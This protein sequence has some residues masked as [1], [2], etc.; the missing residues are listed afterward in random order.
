MDTATLVVAAVLG[1]SAPAVADMQAER[2]GALPDDALT[3]GYANPKVTADN[4]QKTVCKAGWALKAQPQGKYLS[5]ITLLQIRNYGVAEKDAAKYVMDFRIP[6]SVGG[7]PTDPANLWPQRKDVAWNAVV[8][9]KLETYVQ[10]ELCAG[11]MSLKDA[12]GVFQKNWIDVFQLYCG[13]KPDAKC[14]PPGTAVQI[15]TP[16]KR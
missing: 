13:P 6:L 9:N 4:L 11:H 16:T 10:S 12:Q 14:N 1:L 7:H 5:K 2:A 15:E 8:K 3:P